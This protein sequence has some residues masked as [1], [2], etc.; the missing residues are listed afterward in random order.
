MALVLAPISV[1]RFH[2]TIRSLVAGSVVAVLIIISA[3]SY[4]GLIYTGPLLAGLT[5][6]MAAVLLSTML[7]NLVVASVGRPA[8]MA[9]NALGPA[10]VIMAALAA[11]LAQAL[12]ARGLTDPMRMAE[13]VAG[14]CGAVTLATALLFIALGSFRAGAT[15]QLLPYPV[16]SGYFAGIGW[17]L[18]A[19][20]L[21]LSAGTQ[22]L[23]FDGVMTNAPLLICIG[24]GLLVIWLPRRLGHWSVLPAMLLTGL[25]GYHLIR[26][27]LGIDLATAEA[28]G[29]LMGPFPTGI[30]LRLPTFGAF[31]WI[32]GALLWSLAPTIAIHA[33]VAI[34]TQIIYLNGIELGLRK[35]VDIDRELIKV[36]AANLFGGFAGGIIGGPSSAYTG[37]LSQQ[38][39]TSRLGAA[40]PAIWLAVLLLLGTSTLDYMPRFVA[41]ATLLANGYNLLVQ[42]LRDDARTLPRHEMVL[43]VLVLVA[44]VWLGIIGGLSIGILVAIALFAWNYRRIPVIRVA[45]SG[46]DYRSSV[47]RAPEALAIL[48][49]RGEATAV[50][51]LQGYLFF[52][53]AAALRAAVV[54][55]CGTRGARLGMLI[56]D[57]QD[58]VGMDSSA[59]TAF[60][61]VSQLA[62]DRGFRIALTGLAPSLDALVTRS[63]LLGPATG[64]IA[65][66]TRDDALQ[67]AEER[68]LAEAGLADGITQGFASHMSAALDRDVRESRLAPYLERRTLT[69]GD[70]LIRQGDT[71]DALYFVEAGTVSVQLERP[72]QPNLRMRTT[73]AGTLVGEMALYRGGTRSASIIA[74]DACLVARMSAASLARMEQDDPELASLLQR[75]LIMQLADKLADSNRLLD[76]ALR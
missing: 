40:T 62:T 65:F 43:A 30:L 20:G 52:L 3:V 22:S 51:R 25:I 33:L 61:K 37:F 48:R 17:Q 26:L 54:A 57:F 39:G 44:T 41:G 21:T 70:V 4:A 58:V 36:G 67:H 15:S 35:Q 49:E 53:N 50:Y 8:G 71:A 63:G 64:L 47:V 29:W 16:I 76:I 46:A 13:V 28:Q 74:E 14:V 1:G 2:P 60:R 56:L 10:V 73:T 69:A 31:R 72:G 24:F 18:I 42:R 75:F 9:T 66:P 7:V 5:T 68:L 6:G 34:I 11:T 55:R 19:G 27:A 32:D 23:S 12:A 38:G 45:L 59:F